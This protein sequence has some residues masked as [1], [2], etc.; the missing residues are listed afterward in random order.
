MTE[1]GDEEGSEEE[2]AEPTVEAVS[3][4]PQ[5]EKA[6]HKTTDSITAVIFFIFPSPLS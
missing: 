3:P 2:G 6:K 1:D 5:A 4:E